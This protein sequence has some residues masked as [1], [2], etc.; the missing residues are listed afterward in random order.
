MKYNIHTEIVSYALGEK[1]FK[2]FLATPTTDNKVPGVLVMHAWR[3]L[4]EFARKKAIAL[5]E[6]GYVAMAADLYGDGITAETD[7]EAANL[8]L[9]LFLDRELLQAFLKKAYEV[10]CNKPFVDK[11]KVA[12][13]GFCF[14]GLAAIELFRSELSLRGAVSFHAILGNKIGTNKAKT[15]PLA[16]GIKG[17]LLVLHGHDDPLVSANEISDFQKELTNAKVDWQMVVYG[18]TSHAFTNPEAHDYANGLIFNA[19]ANKRSWLSM[20]HFFEEIFT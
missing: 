12:A 18:N 7:E 15:T 14:G 5:A 11:N 6:L 17:K 19:E 4:D 8:M 1:T 2:G 16:K 20:R 9:P 3:G 13:I 10:L